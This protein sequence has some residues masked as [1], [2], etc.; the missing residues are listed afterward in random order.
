MF[1]SVTRA[2]ARRH[3]CVPADTLKQLTQL[4]NLS[5]LNNK[6][7]TPIL[8]LAI[9][10][11]LRSLHLGGNPLEYF[12]ELSPA[13]ALHALSLASLS[14]SAD[15]AFAAFCVTLPKPAARMSIRRSRTAALDDLLALLFRRSS[16]QHPLLAGGLAEMAADRETRATILRVD[17]ALPQ[18]VNMV[19]SENV[20]VSTKACEV[21]WQLAEEA[22]AAAAMV[23]A[24]VGSAVRKLLAASDRG[25]CIAGLQVCS[26]SLPLT[27]LSGLPGPLLGACGND[28]FQAR[29]FAHTRLLSVKRA[30]AAAPGSAGNC[31][32]CRGGAAA[33]RP[34]RESTRAAAAASR[35]QR[36]LRRAPRALLP[37]I[38]AHQQSCAAGE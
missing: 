10:T 32:R 8:D 11:R 34:H 4:V 18:L 3:T 15:D 25:M 38:P 2:L 29:G 22:G 13:T 37:R 7:K 28:V 23:D 26:C 14:L 36:H 12:P 24:A 9:L 30:A 6:L 33:V 27:V 21:L 20:V 5:L 17:R 35:R 16:C 19:R 1:A 31:K